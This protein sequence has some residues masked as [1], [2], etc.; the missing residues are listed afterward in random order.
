MTFV[1]AARLE[2]HDSLMPLLNRVKASLLGVVPE[3][4]QA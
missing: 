1:A 3:R 4:S 2:V